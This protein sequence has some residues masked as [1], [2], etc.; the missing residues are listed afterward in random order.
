MAY[1]SSRFFTILFGGQNNS[2]FLADTWEFDGVDWLNR[3]PNLT[4][5]PGIRA[6]HAMA[7]DS[8]QQKTVLLEALS[9]IAT[10]M[11]RGSGMER[12]V[13]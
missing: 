3:S 7:F 5:Q 10:I 11:T 2:N 13:S 4:T 1:D 8:V 12:G 9:E 6:A